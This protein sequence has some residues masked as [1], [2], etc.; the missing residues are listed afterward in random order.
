MLRDCGSVEPPGEVIN[1]N[2]HP[3]KLKRF[4]VRMDVA[5]P[6]LL[7]LILMELFWFGIRCAT[8]LSDIRDSLRQLTG[9]PEQS[10]SQD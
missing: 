8:Y 1:S 6:I 2:I 7:L 9:S 10:A 3:T 5:M 4:D